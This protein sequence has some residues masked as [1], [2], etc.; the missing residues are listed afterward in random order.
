MEEKRKKIENQLRFFLVMV[1]LI[2]IS[3]SARLFYLQVINQEVYQTR[4]ERNRIRLLAIEPRRGDI[5]D[6]NEQV[7]ATSKP[8]FSITISHLDSKQEQEK[9]V[10]NLAELLNM[11]DLDAEAIYKMV[12][13]HYRKFEPVE[14]VKIPW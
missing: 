6:A 2:F 7:L 13:N 3:L 10:K 1:I 5:I 12:S 8:V 9:A 11:P 14:I 4:S